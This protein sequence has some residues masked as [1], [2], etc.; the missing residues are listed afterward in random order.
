M[1]KEMIYV[2]FL[3]LKQLHNDWRL[4]NHSLRLS[5]VQLYV[6]VIFYTSLYTELYAANPRD[7]VKN[8]LAAGP[9]G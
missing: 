1:T 3:K 9:D 8:Y 5:Y 6:F 2:F 7:A 4:S